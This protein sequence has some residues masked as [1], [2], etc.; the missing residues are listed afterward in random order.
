MNYDIRDLEDTLG[1]LEGPRGEHGWINITQ[2][3]RRLFA[4]LLREKIWLFDHPMS[5]EKE[6]DWRMAET[7]GKLAEQERES[8]YLISV[9]LMERMSNT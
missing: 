5:P 7:A 1:A 6:T 8:Y 2:E 3:E 9:N 4:T